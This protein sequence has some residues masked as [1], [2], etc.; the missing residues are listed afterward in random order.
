MAEPPVRPRNEPSFSQALIKIFIHLHTICGLISYGPRVY[1]QFEV[2][3]RSD[4]G[5]SITTAIDVC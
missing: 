5:R 4:F 1:V 2:W 3:G